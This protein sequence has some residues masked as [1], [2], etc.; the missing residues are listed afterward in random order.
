MH[1]TD[2]KNKIIKLFLPNINS[3]GK[4]FIYVI[5]EYKVIYYVRMKIRFL[6][7]LKITKYIKTRVEN[8]IIYIILSGWASSDAKLIL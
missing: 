8:N 7:I 3:N 4:T 2:S 1:F 6:W 5:H